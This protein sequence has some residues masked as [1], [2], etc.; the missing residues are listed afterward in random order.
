MR[1]WARK[2]VHEMR[3]DMKVTDVEYQ[4]DGTKATFFTAEQRI[5]FRDLIA[6]L[7]DVASRC[8]ST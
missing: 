4:A 5:D 7:A 2:V 8:A 3:L 1:C 6:S